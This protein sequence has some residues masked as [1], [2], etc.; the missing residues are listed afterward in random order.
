[1]GSALAHLG[2][3]LQSDREGDKNA[4]LICTPHIH[5]VGTSLRDISSM[6]CKL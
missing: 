3:D 5:Y 1:M 6:L 4:G 2:V